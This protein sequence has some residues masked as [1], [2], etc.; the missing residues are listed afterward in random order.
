VKLSVQSACLINCRVKALIVKA[1]VQISAV[2]TLLDSISA[3]MIGLNLIDAQLSAVP[4]TDGKG[5]KET[6]PAAQLHRQLLTHT[7]TAGNL[8][9]E[10]PLQLVGCG[11]RKGLPVWAWT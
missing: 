8:H 3:I 1:V 9:K 11:Y 6:T 10:V 7:M 5:P 4:R 2:V